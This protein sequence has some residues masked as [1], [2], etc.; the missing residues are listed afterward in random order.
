SSRTPQQRP[1][2][3]MPCVKPHVRSWHKK[4]SAWLSIANGS[5]CKAA[6][7]DRLKLNAS[8]CVRAGR[9]YSLQAQGDFRGTAFCHLFL[10]V[11]WNARPFLGESRN[12]IALFTFKPFNRHEAWYP[13]ANRV[14]VSWIGD[15]N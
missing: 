10:A 7:L 9:H 4:G 2:S 14:A 8:N 11:I 12:G 1:S 5:A 15:T 6:L 13:I 3:L